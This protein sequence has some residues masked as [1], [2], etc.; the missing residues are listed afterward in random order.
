MAKSMCSE[1][2][3][4]D[5]YDRDKGSTTNYQFSCA[6]EGATLYLRG[7]SILEQMYEG[8][9]IAVVRHVRDNY[10]S[11]E[12]YARE[13]KNMT[14]VEFWNSMIVV[15]GTIKTSAWMVA[16]FTSDSGGPPVLNVEFTR[17]PDSKQPAA[18][19]TITNSVEHRIGP[20]PADGGITDNDKSQCVFLRFY[21]FMHRSPGVLSRVSLFS[22]VA[23][24]ANDQRLTI[25][26]GRPR[27]HADMNNPLPSKSDT[28]TQVRLRYFCAQFGSLIYRR[29]MTLLSIQRS[30]I[31]STSVISSTS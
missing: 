6:H 12:T 14:V 18:I 15:T 25:T 23:G 29:H 31:S 7:P 17:N 13:E 21:K 8:D 26:K 10:K 22:R 30:D 2:H 1:S 11:W 19:Q 5:G 27:K 4:S 3:N 24:F 16:A 20:Y 9:E 28:T